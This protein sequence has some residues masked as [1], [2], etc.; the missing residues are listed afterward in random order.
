MK[1]RQLCRPFRKARPRF[2]VGSGYGILNGWHSITS[3]GLRPESP[4][5]N[6]AQPWMG[7]RPPSIENPASR[8]AG[9]LGRLDSDRRTGRGSDEPTSCFVE[10]KAMTTPEARNGDSGGTSDTA[11]PGCWDVKFT[12]KPVSQ[13]TWRPA[14]KPTRLR[15]I[16]V[17][18][19]SKLALGRAAVRG[20]I[21][22]WS[23]V[24][25]APVGRVRWQRSPAGTEATAAQVRP[26][27]I[28]V[29]EPKPSDRTTLPVPAF[30]PKAGADASS[31]V[32]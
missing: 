6:R 3:P 12:V 18:S 22:C 1:H 28:P 27:W 4:V 8:G 32:T 17:L 31:V 9:R 23:V 25:A 21:D 5:D 15:E 2:R 30:A 11:R 13:P 16:I 10:N 20:R 19:S 14:R 26:P 24:M 29:I 7:S